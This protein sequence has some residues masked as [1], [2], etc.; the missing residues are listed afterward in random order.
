MKYKY[1][2][3]RDR[4]T[5]MLVRAD[6]ML[7]ETELE[8]KILRYSGWGESYPSITFTFLDGGIHS[9][10]NPYDYYKNER[11]KKALI[12]IQ[13]HFDEF[14]DELTVIDIE[15]ILKEKSNSTE[16]YIKNSFNY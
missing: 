3:I 11:T 10:N 14:E 15:F 2:E 13:D 4:G 9:Y 7:G 8:G 16:S 5:L 1:F 12:Y 6:K